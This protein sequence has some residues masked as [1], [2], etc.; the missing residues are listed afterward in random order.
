MDNPLEALWGI[1]LCLVAIFFVCMAANPNFKEAVISFSIMALLLAGKALIS[2]LISIGVV[3]ASYKAGQWAL[4][5]ANSYY[6]RLNDVEQAAYNFQS[7]LHGCKDGIEKLDT[8][9]VNK[10]FSTTLE[11]E[12]FEQRIKKLEPVTEVQAQAQISDV[13]KQFTGEDS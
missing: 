3:T 2:V 11:L 13:T 7:E 6:T 10:I 4:G 8:K 5:F 12:S 9:L 1:G